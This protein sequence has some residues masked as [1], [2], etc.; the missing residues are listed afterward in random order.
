MCGCWYWWL[1]RSIGQLLIV[2]KR[3]MSWNRRAP[4]ECIYAAGA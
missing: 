2:S 4:V 1:E 3:K